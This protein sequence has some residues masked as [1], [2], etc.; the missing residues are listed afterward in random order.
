M[1][2]VY[3]S[4]A[5]DRHYADTLTDED[6]DPST[7]EQL[8]P[9][10]YDELRKL[11]AAKLAQEK[12]DQTR[13][14]TAVFQPSAPRNLWP[15]RLLAVD[16]FAQTGGRATG[17]WTNY[18]LGT[19]RKA[20]LSAAMLGKQPIPMMSPWLLIAVPLTSTTRRPYPFP[21]IPK[22]AEEEGHDRVRHQNCIS[23][24]STSPPA[25]G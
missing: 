21:T 14:A 8:L 16:A 13:Q 10:G 19:N 12:P 23:I 20:T 7:A 4:R 1:T 17:V 15:R 6:G 22:E 5:Y 3:E 9:L 18:Y 25:S 24:V 11:A 2:V